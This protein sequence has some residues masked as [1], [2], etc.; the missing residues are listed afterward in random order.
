M[1]RRR[2]LSSGGILDSPLTF[3]VIVSAVHRLG[4][5]KGLAESQYISFGEEREAYHEL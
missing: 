2:P 3:L 5:R 4:S 1:K